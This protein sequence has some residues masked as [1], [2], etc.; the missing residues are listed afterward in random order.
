VFILGLAF[1]IS[2][3]LRWV[4]LRWI[5]IVSAVL[6]VWNLGLLF[7]FA[8]GMIPRDA[9]ISFREVVVNYRDIPVEAYNFARDYFSGRSELRERFYYD[10]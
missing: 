7:Q 6:I 8:I 1:I 4:R 9:P 5:V 3:V 10:E 2:Q